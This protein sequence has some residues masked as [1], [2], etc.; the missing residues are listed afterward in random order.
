MPKESFTHLHQQEYNKV[1]QHITL[2][3]QHIKK[4]LR[5]L[6]R[7]EVEWSPKYKLTKNIKRLWYQLRKYRQGKVT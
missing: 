5:H 4:N 1:L 6:Y 7:G 3:R 2:T